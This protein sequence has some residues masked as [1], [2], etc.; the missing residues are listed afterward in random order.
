MKKCYIK[1]ITFMNN[2][3][4]INNNKIKLLVT[5]YHL[6]FYNITL[7]NKTHY[8]MYLKMQ[9]YYMLILQDLQNIH[10]V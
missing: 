1:I 4:L 9:Q 10:Q 8:L 3:Q 7:K 2:Y 5:Y 6:I